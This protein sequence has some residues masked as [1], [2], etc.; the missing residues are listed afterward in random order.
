MNDFIPL[1]SISTQPFDLDAIQIA[2]PC[3]ADWG[4]MSGDE[5]TR[6]CK[7]CAKNVYNLSALTRAEA[8]R[9]IEEKEGHLCVRL[10]RREDGT[11]ITSDCSVGISSVRRAP[12][13]VQNLFAGAMAA[14]LAL[15]GAGANAAPKTAAPILGQPKMGKPT[16][17]APRMPE[18]SE[19]DMGVMAPVMGRIAPPK[20]QKS[21]KKHAKHAATAKSKTKVGHQR[22]RR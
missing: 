19:A 21:L 15:F 2:Q 22:H 3:R 11:V 8:A 4:A 17:G 6:H 7:A 1:T 5:Q 14:V 18:L 13:L 9:L 12:R 20:K 16:M 10:Y